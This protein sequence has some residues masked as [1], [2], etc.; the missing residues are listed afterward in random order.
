MPVFDPYSIFLP[1]KELDADTAALFAGR[2][3][4]LLAAWKSFSKPESSVAFGQRGVGKSS[5]GRILIGLIDGESARKTS[6][7]SDQR[8]P[9]A[10]CVRIAWSPGLQSLEHLLYQLFNPNLEAKLSFAQQFPE[11][12]KKYRNKF[13]KISLKELTAEDDASGGKLK[14]NQVLVRDVFNTIEDAFFAVPKKSDA[15]GKDGLVIMIDDMD[16]AIA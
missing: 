8:L 1:T 16:Q 9:R 11:I 6:A 12:A 3:E 4:I 13:E 5:L 2:R 14:P 15:V 10:A 7:K